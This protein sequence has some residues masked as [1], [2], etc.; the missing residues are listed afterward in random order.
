MKWTNAAY[1][2]SRE[3]LAREM[4]ALQAELSVIRRTNGL[5]SGALAQVK[6]EEEEVRALRCVS[7]VR[8]S[9]ADA[10]PCPENRLDWNLSR[11]KA[12]LRERLQSWMSRL[13]TC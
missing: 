2:L 6:D 9:Q 10:F 3:A 13:T 7:C 5:Q 12:T 11:N 1:F 4:D 8:Y